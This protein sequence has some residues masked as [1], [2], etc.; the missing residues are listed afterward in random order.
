MGASQAGSGHTVQT[1]WHGKTY[2]K[3]HTATGHT[4]HS[5]RPDKTDSQVGIEHKEQSTLPS[6]TNIDTTGASQA[7][8]AHTQSSRPGKSKTAKSAQASQAGTHRKR[9]HAQDVTFIQIGDPSAKI[10]RTAPTTQNPQETGSRDPAARKR[11]RHH[12]PKRSQTS[13]Q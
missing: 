7:G 3:P 9:A 8:S 12:S 2:I 6:K 11:S 10:P 1:S 5:A 13:G 4:A